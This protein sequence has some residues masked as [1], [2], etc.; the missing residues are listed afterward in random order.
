MV[1]IGAAWP[2]PISGKSNGMVS[3]PNH[4]SIHPHKFLCGIKKE[5]LFSPFFPLSFL[6]IAVLTVLHIAVGYTEEVAVVCLLHAT[7]ERICHP[8]CCSDEH[9][10]DKPYG[11]LF[12]YGR[13]NLGSPEE[14]DS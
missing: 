6:G 1:G 14:T 2:G 10:W 12:A 7:S 11:D 9:K 4:L 3:M 8:Q 13:M 5:S